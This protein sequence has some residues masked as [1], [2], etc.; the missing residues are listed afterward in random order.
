VD[1]DGNVDGN[2]NGKGNMN[3]RAWKSQL[4]FIFCIIVSVL[5]PKSK[6]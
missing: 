3:S 6:T 2:G 1:G 5:C 4:F